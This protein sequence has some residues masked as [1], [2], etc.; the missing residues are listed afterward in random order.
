MNSFYLVSLLQKLIFT[1]EFTDN[2][3][4]A[5]LIASLSETRNARNSNSIKIFVTYC[6]YFLIFADIHKVFAD[7]FM[8]DIHL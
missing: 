6:T 7:I 5:L 4:Q 2:I 1:F 8:P 3:T